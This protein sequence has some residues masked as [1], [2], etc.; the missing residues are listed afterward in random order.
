MEPKENQRHPLNPPYWTTFTWI[1]AFLWL[2]RPFWL[3]VVLLPAKSYVE[4]SS[5]QWVLAEN[6]S[7]L[8]EI[9]FPW[10]WP[11]SYVQ[12]TP[13][14][15][16]VVPMFGGAR[17]PVPVAPLSTV[18]WEMLGL[19]V[20]VIAV[21]TMAL[22]YCSQKLWRQF[23]LLGLFVLVTAFSLYFGLIPLISRLLNSEIG[24]TIADGL[25]FS[26]IVGAI[27]ILAAEKYGFDWNAFRRL[28]ANKFSSDR[29]IANDGSPDD[30]LAHASQ[31]DH[32]GRW[33]EAIGLYR[34]AATRWPEQRKYAMN[35]IAAIE[36][37]QA[38]GN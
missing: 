20:V 23:S 10:G 13:V 9:P 21:A 32:Q 37:K 29:A 1:G 28:I 19:N 2:W 36:Q 12:P 11:F 33:D 35:C 25:Y 34:D 18:H 3:N 31:L 27:A 8:A 16:P 30:V 6:Y 5:G 38:A 7:T 14:V 17:P 4:D 15:L 26:P 24:I 22:I